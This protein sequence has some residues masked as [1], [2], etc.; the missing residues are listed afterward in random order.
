MKF[1]QTAHEEVD[2]L[3]ATS[4]LMIENAI[5]ALRNSDKEKSIEVLDLHNKLYAQEKK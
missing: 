3:L 5:E 2:Q 4:T 1:S